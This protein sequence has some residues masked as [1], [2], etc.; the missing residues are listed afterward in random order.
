MNIANK[1]VT[2]TN[3]R[4]MT[5][6]YND[7]MNDSFTIPKEHFIYNNEEL[8]KSSTFT[9]TTSRSSTSSLSKCTTFLSSNLKEAKK[10]PDKDKEHRKHRKGIKKTKKVTFKENFVEVVE[11]STLKYLFFPVPRKNCNNKKDTIKC[12]CIIF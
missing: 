1:K 9:P 7:I 5:D 4:S 8:I 3:Q 11:V 6:V 12:K 2:K 10:E